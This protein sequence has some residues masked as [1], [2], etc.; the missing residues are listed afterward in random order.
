MSKAIHLSPVTSG[1]QIADVARMARE[2]WNEYYVALIGQAQVDYMVDKFQSAEAM[3]SQIDSGYEYFRIQQSGENIGYAAIRHDA[4]DARV[5]I[6]KLYLLAAHRKSG[7][8][9]QALALI[10]H[11]A[12]ERGATHLWL[13]VNKG[14]PSVQAY[15][16]LGFKIV[17]ALVMDIGGGYVMDDYKMEKAVSPVSIR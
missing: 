12:R 6:S 3:Q 16:R 5:F 15:E 14:N 1:T 13:T 2:V 10:E 7:A 8:G 11:R 9:R 17:E 4:D